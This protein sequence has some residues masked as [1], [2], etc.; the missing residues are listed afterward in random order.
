PGVLLQPLRGFL[1]VAHRH[2]SPARHHGPQAGEV[3]APR[4]VAGRAVAGAAR[5]S[6]P[7]LS[8]DA[9]AVLVARPPLEELLHRRR[10]RVEDLGALLAPTVPSPGPGG[11]TSLA[12]GTTG[13]LGRPRRHLSGDGELRSE[14]RRV[15]KGSRCELLSEQWTKR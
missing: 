13:G 4:A 5:A 3:A 15:G 8:A 6:Q 14:E 1:L 10:R 12:R 9:E 2:R 7:A 11:G